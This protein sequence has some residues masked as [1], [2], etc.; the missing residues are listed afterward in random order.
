MVKFEVDDSTKNPPD[1]DISEDIMI[2][3][4]TI[5]SFS[6]DQCDYKENNKSELKKNI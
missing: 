2:E 3:V 6:C 1:N 5:I 4:E